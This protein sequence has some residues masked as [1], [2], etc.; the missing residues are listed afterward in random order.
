MATFLES[1]LCTCKTWTFNQAEEITG[2]QSSWMTSEL[3]P[4]GSLAS[5]AEVLNQLKA[6]ACRNTGGVPGQGDDCGL[7]PWN[8][9]WVMRE[10][11]GI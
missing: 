6:V 4:L 3:W 2:A 8:E 1:L 9:M 5:V 7:E 10:S 11:I